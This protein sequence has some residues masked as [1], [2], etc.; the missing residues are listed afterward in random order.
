MQAAQPFTIQVAQPLLDDLQHRLAATR[1]PAAM[2]DLGWTEGTNAGYLRELIAYWQT[3]FDWPQ[4]E[5]ML[6][7]FAHFKA[8]V[9]GR[10]IHFVHQLG[11]GPNPTPLLLTHGW[12]DSFFR[13]R[14][15]IPR[16]TDPAR[17]GGDPND[18]F[19]VVAP[20]LPGFG[21]TGGAAATAEETAHLWQ[22]LMREVLG[23]EHFVAAGGDL[24]TGVTQYLALRYPAAVRAI[25]LTDVGFPDGTEDVQSFSP[26]EQEFAAYLQKWWPQEGAYI[27]LQSTKPHT[28]AYGLSDS[29]VGLAAWMVEKFYT[30]SDCHGDLESRFTKDDL[31][32]HVMLYWVTQTMG[33]AMRT[34]LLNAQARY[35]SP[36]GPQPLERSTVPAGIAVFPA[37]GPLPREW[38]ERRVNVQRFTQMPRGGHFAAWEEPELLAQDL[39][40]FFRPFRPSPAGPR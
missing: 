5:A 39:T 9:G 23:Y 2:P 26:A 22:E 11:K 25:H 6:N 12:P 15:L 8:P 37:D 24:G 19:T 35:A 14:H 30:W 17:F 38:A 21:F 18:S 3:G 28:L 4:Q 32:T 1:W 33:P 20:S 13:F 36:G 31:L 7:E 29:P 27:M 40:A 34:Y 16:L 10:P